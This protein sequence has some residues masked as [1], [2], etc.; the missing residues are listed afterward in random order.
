MCKYFGNH[1]SECGQFLN[2]LP[3][4][5][6]SERAFQMLS[7]A[8]EL[9]QLLRRTRQLVQIPQDWIMALTDAMVGYGLDA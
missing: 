1:E 5:L 2:L 7:P 6:R 8:G 9:V 3:Q 4:Q